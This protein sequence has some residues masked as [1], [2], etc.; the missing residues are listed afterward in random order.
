MRAETPTSE[1][2]LA[3]LHNTQASAPL[4]GRRI[5][6]QLYTEAPSPLVWGLLQAGAAVQ[7]AIP[8]IYAPRADEDRVKEAI[9]TMAVGKCDCIAFTSAAQVDRIWQVA[10]SL[11]I[12][13][14]LKASL[15]RTRVAA[16]GP[17]AVEA[18]EDRDIHP[19]IVPQAPF[20]MRRLA[21]AIAEGL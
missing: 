16:I 2:V 10:V 1:G 3:T 19:S 17:I 8:Y 9:E 12:E 14:L 18:L 15:K 21:Q 11:N 4:A 20:S 5:G 7:T 6:V 13:P